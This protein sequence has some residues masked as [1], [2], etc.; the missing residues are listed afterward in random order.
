MRDTL[1]RKGDVWK[2]CVDVFVRE[3]GGDVERQRERYEETER[4]YRKK[5]ILKIATL[6][7]G[8]VPKEYVISAEG[9]PRILDRSRAVARVM[10]AGI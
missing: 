3:R 2:E 1:L 4:K 6:K 9:L 8:S 5:E 10:P 7:R